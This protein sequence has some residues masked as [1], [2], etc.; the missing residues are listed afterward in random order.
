MPSRIPPETAAQIVAM[1]REDTPWSLIATTLR[2]DPH[3]VA[4]HCRRAG[5]QPPEKACMAT[6]LAARAYLRKETPSMC[7]A[8]KQMGISESAVRH[9]IW[10]R[11]PN[12]YG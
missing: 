1:A 5:L 10:R 8:A 12:R 4:R 3:T 9:Y 11:N 7:A 6:K 2:V